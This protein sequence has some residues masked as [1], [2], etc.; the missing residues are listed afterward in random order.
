MYY[1]RMLLSLVAIFSISLSPC[2]ARLL[3]A[4]VETV[5]PPTLLKSKDELKKFINK[6]HAV[7]IKF[8]A[9]WCGAC[10]NMKPLDETMQ[11]KFNTRISF[12][13]IDID[14]T[15]EAAE[16]NQIKGVPTYIFFRQ[17]KEIARHV[18]SMDEKTYTE[19]LQA[20]L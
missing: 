10:A 8:F 2:N 16:E 14:Q 19:K 17:G 7:I 3:A 11:Q 13:L 4:S 18:G 9:S 12:A 1:S 5:T 6:N 15:K 20:L